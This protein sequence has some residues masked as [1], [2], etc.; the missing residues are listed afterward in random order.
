MIN[1]APAKELKM[2]GRNTLRPI[3]AATIMSMSNLGF[4]SL[5]DAA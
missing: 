1:Q 3:H 4:S 5:T 2:Y